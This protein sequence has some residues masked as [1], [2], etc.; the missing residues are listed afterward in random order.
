M[1]TEKPQDEETQDL[2]ETA[3]TGARLFYRAIRAANDQDD[4]EFFIEVYEQWG[5]LVN[6]ALQ[7]CGRAPRDSRTGRARVSR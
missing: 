1:N 5:P 7:A 4:V 3:R 2:I 6:T